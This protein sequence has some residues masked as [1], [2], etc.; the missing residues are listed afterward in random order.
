MPGKSGEWSEGVSHG[1]FPWCPYADCLRIL[2]SIIE[3]RFKAWEHMVPFK[4]I[5]T[6]IMC[7]ASENAMHYRPPQCDAIFVHQLAC[8][9]IFKSRQSKARNHISLCPI[10]PQSNWC[11]IISSYGCISP[12]PVSLHN[13]HAPDPWCI[14]LNLVRQIWMW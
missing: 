4:C 1:P 13:A 7:A 6:R 11:T 3:P 9:W 14:E 5:W 2:I 12:A 8:Q 10:K